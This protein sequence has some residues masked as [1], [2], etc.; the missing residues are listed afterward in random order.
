MAGTKEGDRPRGPLTRRGL[1]RS[2]ANVPSA[3]TK[4]LC[5]GT[6]QPTDRVHFPDLPCFTRRGHDAVYGCSMLPL[7]FLAVSRSFTR[8]RALVM[9]ANGYWCCVGIV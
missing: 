9:R 3:D 2:Y 1:S 6:P 4:S 8:S 5:E 7:S